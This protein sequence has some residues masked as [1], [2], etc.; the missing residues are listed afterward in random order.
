MGEI[1]KT[2]FCVII[3]LLVSIVSSSITLKVISFHEERFN[4]T[5]S[6]YV[7][8]MNPE[9]LP[10][11]F[12]VCFSVFI[13]QADGSTVVSLET[14]SGHNILTMKAPY[15]LESW[16]I[17]KKTWLPFES[18]DTGWSNMCFDINFD[19]GYVHYSFDGGKVKKLSENPIGEMNI[20]DDYNIFVG[21]FY[22][23]N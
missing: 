1:T 12:I 4:Y 14:S 17:F 6:S 5:G 20:A 22:C 10:K 18:S 3:L 21:E 23:N 9:P 19:L 2:I 13:T 16:I 8:I 11:H 15:W 7:Q